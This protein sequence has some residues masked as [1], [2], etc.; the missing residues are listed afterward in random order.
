MLK[1]VAFDGDGTTYRGEELIPEA[2]EVIDWL[3]SQG[4]PIYIASNTSSKDSEA[5]FERF[6]GAIRK[7]RIITSVDLLIDYVARRYKRV[8][9]IC[10]DYIRRRWERTCEISE[11]AEVV[12]VSHTKKL[13]YWQFKVAMDNLFSGKPL[14]AAN[15]DRYYMS[16]EGLLPGTGMIVRA[17]SENFVYKPKVFGKPEPLMLNIIME[18]EG[19]KPEEVAMVGDMLETDV[20]A[21]KRAGCISI[22]VD[23][24]I[25]QLVKERP[26]YSTD[27][28]KLKAVL[29]K[30]L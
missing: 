22:F 9:P 10:S 19:A 13:D 1:A 7:E 14:L 21:A 5:L 27:H 16:S 2:M 17:L 11:D 6:G 8:W 4:I 15:A 24:G 20:G 29:E 28:K 18:R 26:D 3:E 12:C 30:L 25:P 23:S